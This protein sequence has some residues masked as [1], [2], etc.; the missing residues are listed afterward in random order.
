[1]QERSRGEVRK[2]RRSMGRRELKN[3]DFFFF[4]FPN[5]T[6]K[7]VMVEGQEVLRAGTSEKKDGFIYLWD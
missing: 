5:Y 2:E 6:H 7:R 4:F 1:M 3:Y